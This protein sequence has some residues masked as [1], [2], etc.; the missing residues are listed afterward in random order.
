MEKGWLDDFFRTWVREHTVPLTSG[1]RDPDYRLY[2]LLPPW[3]ISPT[4]AGT[5]QGASVYADDAA[6]DSGDWLADVDHG[7]NLLLIGPETVAE[8][9]RLLERCDD[10]IAFH[11]GGFS[12]GGVNYAGEDLAVLHTMGHPD[13]PGRFITLFCPLGEGG[14]ERLRLIWYYGK[15]TT[16]IWD[17]NQTLLRRVYEPAAKIEQ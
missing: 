11:D 9:A 8:H 12:V 13:D 7:D 5:L 3:Q 16:V 15:D 17:A 2:R 1:D 4:I 10:P 6:G 14:W